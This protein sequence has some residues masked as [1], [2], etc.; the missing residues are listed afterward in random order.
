MTRMKGPLSGRFWAQ[1]RRFGQERATISSR[2]RKSHEWSWF[3]RFFL[4]DSVLSWN[5]KT[6]RASLTDFPEVRNRKGTETGLIIAFDCPSLNN[7]LCIAQYSDIVETW[8]MSLWLTRIAEAWFRI[9]CP[10]LIY[11]VAF[12][13][14]LNYWLCCLYNFSHPVHICAFVRIFVLRGCEPVMRFSWLTLSGKCRF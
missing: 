13:K 9:P 1:R 12:L 4:D 7:S 14:A 2:L 8:I 6:S 11:S 10:I 3:P 5:V